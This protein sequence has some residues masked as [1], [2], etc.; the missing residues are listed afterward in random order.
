MGVVK[1]QGDT[2]SQFEDTLLNPLTQYSQQFTGLSNSSK[3]ATEVMENF[4]TV[5][6]NTNTSF[7]QIISVN[8]TYD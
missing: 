4:N 3:N 2:V 6:Q 7:T 1:N 5:I 8:K